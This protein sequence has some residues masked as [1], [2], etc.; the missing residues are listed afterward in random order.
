LATKF[1]SKFKSLVG[2]AFAVKQA[3]DA[4]GYKRAHGLGAV[5]AVFYKKIPFKN[6]IPALAKDSLVL[7]LSTRLKKLRF[8]VYDLQ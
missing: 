3:A 6:S 8:L 7:N 4:F 1:E 2:C 5:K